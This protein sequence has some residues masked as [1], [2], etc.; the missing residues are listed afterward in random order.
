MNKESEQILVPI[1]KLTEEVSIKD[2]THVLNEVTFEDNLFIHS[3]T[4]F[5]PKEELEK[6]FADNIQSE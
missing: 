6:I 2:L 5:Y 3:V 4:V 1:S